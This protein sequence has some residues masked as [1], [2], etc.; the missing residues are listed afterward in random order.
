MHSWFI[1]CSVGCSSASTSR[2]SKRISLDTEG[3]PTSGSRAC[4]RRLDS[5]LPLNRKKTRY[6]IQIVSIFT[7]IYS[8]HFV[9]IVLRDEQR[10]KRERHSLHPGSYSCDPNYG[11]CI[12]KNEIVNIISTPFA[13]PTLKFSEL[14]PRVYIDLILL[15]KFS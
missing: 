4:A 12:H 13:S 14:F 7:F 9:R 15:S 3:N 6:I 2:S 11:M 1:R 5:I 8:H 10:V